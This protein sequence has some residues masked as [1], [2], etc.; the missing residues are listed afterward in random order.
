MFRLFITNPDLLATLRP[1][2]AAILSEQWEPVEYRQ[3]DE[4]LA[5]DPPRTLDAVANKIKTVVS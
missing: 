2:T 3:W 5:A 1:R 4:V